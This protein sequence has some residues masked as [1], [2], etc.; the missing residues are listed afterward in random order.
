MK[1]ESP[2]WNVWYNIQPPGP[3]TLNVTSLID[4]EDEGIDIE[5]KFH[6][7]LKKNPPILVLQLHTKTIF[8]P[9]DQ[10]DTVVRVHYYQLASPG[11]FDGII[12]LDSNGEKIKEID[13]SDILI[14]S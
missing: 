6:S 1:I 7:I 10:G 11:N 8:I 9:R 3:S 13:A 4:M 14:A 12:I 5:L 2:E